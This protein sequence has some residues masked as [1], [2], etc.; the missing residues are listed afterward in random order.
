M[1]YEQVCV[2]GV[3]PACGR[4]VVPE[5]LAEKTDSP[6]NIL[7]TLAENQLRVNVRVCFLDFQFPLLLCASTVVGLPRGVNFLLRLESGRHRASRF[8][9][10]CKMALAV[11]SPF[12]VH[13]TF[14]SVCPLGQWRQ[15]EFW[16]KL[17]GETIVGYHFLETSQPVK[18]RCLVVRSSSFQVM[19][20]G[21]IVEC[22]VLLGV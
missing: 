11:L 4:P 1:P 21:I 3:S 17:H 22:F 8:I 6:S 16:Q 5:T 20:F 14:R 2:P 15:M 18:V 7:G 9:I 13:T 10:P 19:S 12:Q